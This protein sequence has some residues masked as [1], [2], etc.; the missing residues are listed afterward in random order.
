[1]ASPTPSPS[2]TGSPTPTEE[3]AP[4]PTQEPT[5]EPTE[6]PTLEPTEEPTPEPTLELDFEPIELKGRGDKVARF[7]IPE[8]AAAMAAFTHS[9]SGNFAVWAIDESGDETDLLVNDIGRYKGRVLFDEEGHTVAFKIKASAGWT[10]KISPIQKIP[11][12]DGV[13][14]RKGTGDY[15]LVMTGDTGGFAV[16]KATH[17]GSGNF[18][19]WAYGS[20]GTELLV[21][22]IGRYNGEVLLGDAILLE[23][24][25][26]G[27]WTLKLTE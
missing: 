5:A 9:G 16:L 21:N 13:G 10:A 14:T 1:M 23:I 24:K 8:G 17:R 27:A 20:S 25:A 22:D 2:P 7:K 15:V 26:D 11:R 3:P 19:I 18:V 12:W 6:E 4:D